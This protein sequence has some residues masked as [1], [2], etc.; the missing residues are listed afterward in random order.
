[1]E[2]RL[3]LCSTPPE[4][5]VSIHDD[6]HPQRLVQRIWTC[7]Q[8]RVRKGDRLPDVICLSC[9]NNLELLNTFRNTCFRSDKTSRVGSNEYLKVE[10]KE[11]LLEDLI[12]EDQSDSNIRPNISSSP[13][14]E[15]T[16]GGQITSNDKI[17]IPAEKLPLRKALD[18]MCSTRSEL[19][20]K[21]NFQDKSFTPKHNLVTQKTYHAE[22]KLHEC[23]ICSKTFNRIQ[24]LSAHMSVHT[25]GCLV[26]IY[27]L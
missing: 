13:D 18:K 3:C 6:P 24:S 14:D 2:C 22:I 17:D 16:H 27:Q 21:I 4:S 8:L 19:D 10:L 12:W 7:C 25:M 1:M 5:S 23:A 26:K 9:V 20:H 15:E 11:V